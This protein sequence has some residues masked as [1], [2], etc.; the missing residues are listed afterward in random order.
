M[1]ERGRGKGKNMDGKG[2][3]G[4]KERGRKK[5]RG[6]LCPLAKI[7]AGVHDSTEG[8]SQTRSSAVAER[9]TVRCFMSLDISLSH[10]R[11]FF[12]F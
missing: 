10:S 8:R 7:L 4:G 12:T 1:V 11:S 3:G 5:E 2:D 9:P 6:G